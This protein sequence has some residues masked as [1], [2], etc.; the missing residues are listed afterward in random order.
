MQLDA[1]IAEVESKGIAY[2]LLEP[3]SQHTTFRIGGAA[4]VFVS[5]SNTDELAAVI[6]AAKSHQVP[7]FC[8]GRGS[9][10]LV[11]DDGICGAVVSLSALNSISVEGDTIT[12]GAGAS[13][14]ALS[15]A[16]R[17]NSLTGLEFAF[18]IPGSVGGALY[19]NAGA[20]G[21][22]M[23]QV[24]VS[25]ECV[26]NN[27]NKLIL[28]A[29]EMCLGYRTSIF[30]HG[31]LY[32][33]SVSVKLKKGDRT[34]I[35]AQMEELTARRKEKQPLEFPS[36]GST[37]KRPEG[38]FAGALIEKNSLKGKRIGAA[39]VSEKHAGFIINTGGASCK[40]VCTLIKEVQQT[41]YENDKVK[42]EPEVLIL[43]RNL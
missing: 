2:K 14:A 11:S 5:V 34:Q 24:V 28:S 42:L 29:Q 41:V 26:D 30:K 19:M 16:A 12:C 8:I 36:A 27:A 22:E 7:L 38:Y 33:T 13:L 17:D 23:S 3:M 37:F 1:F 6:S 43:G 35:S 39:Q 21:G 10:L 32:I 20:Y 15:L 31:G 4:D 40:D 18:G 25:C 9:N